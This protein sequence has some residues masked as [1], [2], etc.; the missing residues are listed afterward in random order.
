MKF[1]DFDYDPMSAI[2]AFAVIALIFF[3]SRNNFRRFTFK[4]AKHHVI[5]GTVLDMLF[6][7]QKLHDYMTD[8]SRKHKTYRLLSFFRSEL[9]TVDPVIVEYILKT[10]FANYVKVETLFY[11]LNMHDCNKY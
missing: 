2:A 9:Y 11:Y 6:N 8:V 7:F 1:L 4:K 3:I 5:A 10:N